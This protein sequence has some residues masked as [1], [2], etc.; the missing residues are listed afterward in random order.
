MR[1]NELIKP[2]EVNA[3]RRD[4]NNQTFHG[5]VEHDDVRF[6]LKDYMAKYGFTQLGFGGFAS[7]FKSPK[8]KFVLKVFGENP[9]FLKWIAHCQ[10]HQDNPYLPKFQGK[11]VKIHNTYYAVRMESLTHKDEAL[12]T[13][14]SNVIN[15]LVDKSQILYSKSDEEIENSHTGNSRFFITYWDR[16]LQMMP[17]YRQDRDLKA[18]VLAVR[19]IAQ[20]HSIDLNSGNIMFRGDQIVITDPISG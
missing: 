19:Q 11:P 3:F 13:K 18:A 12:Q 16:L 20:G 5:T 14:I 8:H 2:D 9:G 6:N 4:I 17:D 10:E 1:I 7:V 15:F